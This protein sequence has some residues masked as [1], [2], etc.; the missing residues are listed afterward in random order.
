MRVKEFKRFNSADTSLLFM[1]LF[2]V[3]PAGSY[4]DRGIGKL[5]PK[6][7]FNQ[8][9]NSNASCSA[10]PP[11]I[12]T[13]AA[14]GNR[15]P[16]DCKQAVQGYYMV[17]A[18][19]AAPCPVDTYSDNSTLGVGDSCTPCPNGM[20]TTDPGA[21]GKALCLAPPGY[22]LRTADGVITECENGWYK[23]DWNRNNCTYV[24]VLDCIVSS[25]TAAHSSGMHVHVVSSK[26]QAAS[27]S[28]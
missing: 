3:A 6:G 19:T 26:Q 28:S 20:K 11:G 8:N 21:T 16:F 2:A 24:S 27:C 13:A 7:T 15:S 17:D 10:C 1:L 14:E 18:T 23:V 4:M 22:E 25:R 9:P 5:C 12:T